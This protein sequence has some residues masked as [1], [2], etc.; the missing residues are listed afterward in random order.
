MTSEG[1]IHGNK[2]GGGG[3]VEYQNLMTLLLFC[4]SFVVAL[5]NGNF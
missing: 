4:D 5:Y 3:G 2:G 1:Q